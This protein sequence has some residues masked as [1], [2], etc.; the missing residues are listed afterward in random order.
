MDKVD[1]SAE[2]TTNPLAFLGGGAKA[3]TKKTGKKKAPGETGK[4][5][6]GEALKQS[7]LDGLGDLGPVREIA[8]SEEAVQ[9][10]LDEVRSTGD[11]LK[12]RPF[13]GEILRYK[14]AVRNFIHYVVENSYAL[15]KFQTHRR[16]MKGLKPY[17][18]IQVIDGK[19]EELAA[20]ILTGQ[21]DRLELVSKID[22]IAGLLVDL[23]VT[24]RI[25]ERDE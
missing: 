9:D 4:S 22:A 21:T 13:P 23:T 20:G 5:G 2:G 16:E 1:F 7:F 25:R 18:Q 6:F 17:M 12:N 3:G 11:D 19:L 14:Q 24:G 15:E 10:L 8:P